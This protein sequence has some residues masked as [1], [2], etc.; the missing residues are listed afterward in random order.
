MGHLN[1]ATF[2]TGHVVLDGLDRLSVVLE[3][4]IGDSAVKAKVPENSQIVLFDSFVRNALLD[5]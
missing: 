4:R 2:E 1:R 5:R 3:G